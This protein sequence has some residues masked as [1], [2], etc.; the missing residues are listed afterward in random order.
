MAIAAATASATFWVSTR[1]GSCIWACIFSDWSFNWI[2]LGQMNM[3]LYID[4][5]RGLNWIWFSALKG[6]LFYLC[7]CLS[8]LYLGLYLFLSLF[9]SLGFSTFI[10][11]WMGATCCFYECFKILIRSSEYV[12]VYWYGSVAF[13]SVS[14]LKFKIT[15]LCSSWPIK[16]LPTQ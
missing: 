11:N 8:L 2:W 7:L 16:R 6:I 4:I 15:L 12:L 5:K 14:T 3:R 10:R 1:L 13:E 9:L